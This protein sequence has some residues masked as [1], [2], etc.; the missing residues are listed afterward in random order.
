M[1]KRFYALFFILISVIVLCA[2]STSDKESSVQKSNLPKLKIGYDLYA[3]YSYIDESGDCAGI[4]I[5]IL[6]EACHRLGYEPEFINIM[7]GTHGTLLSNGTLDCVCSGFSMTGRERLYQWAGPYLYSQELVVVRANSGIYDL[8]DL[9]DKKIAVQVD[10]KSENFFLT[11]TIPA[12]KD[13]NEICTYRNLEEAFAAFNKGYTD[14]VAAHEAA[15][16]QYTKDSPDLYRY[17][18]TPIVYSQLGIAFDKNA[19]T[20]LVDALDT[21]LNEMNADGTIHSIAKKYDISSDNSVEVTIDE[22]N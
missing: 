7:W 10:T 4:D 21:T 22:A 3:P 18:S 17:L 2:C 16:Q 6:T 5:D 13:V 9:A 12:I 19:D 11:D 1:K 14:A 8:N 15:L 20:S